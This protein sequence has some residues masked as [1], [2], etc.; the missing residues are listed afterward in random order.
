MTATAM[1]RAKQHMLLNVKDIFNPISVSRAS[2]ISAL[3][4]RHRLMDMLDIVKAEPG[5]N[6]RLY[7]Y[8]AEYAF[9]LF[10]ASVLL[11]M[12]FEPSFVGLSEDKFTELC[13]FHIAQDVNDE[14]FFDVANGHEKLPEHHRLI[15]FRDKTLVYGMKGLEDGYVFTVGF[16]KERGPLWSKKTFNSI[17]HAQL[18]MTSILKDRSGSANDFRNAVRDQMHYQ[19]SRRFWLRSLNDVANRKNAVD[20][21]FL[22]QNEYKCSTYG[23]G[24]DWLEAGRDLLASYILDE[25]YNTN[26]LIKHLLS[27]SSFVPENCYVSDIIT[28]SHHFFTETGNAFGLERVEEMKKREANE[29]KIIKKKVRAS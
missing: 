20:R 7:P 9:T 26:R 14:I 22:I 10:K 24:K 3:N 6:K 28:G 21:F 19:D 8:I 23:T 17:P 11:K 12:D 15:L 18:Y 16:N 27:S 29:L 1:E 5:L 4:V 13:V 2:V 25:A